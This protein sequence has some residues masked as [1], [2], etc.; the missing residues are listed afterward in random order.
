MDD[1][2][3]PS[4]QVLDMDKDSTSNEIPDLPEP[5]RRAAPQPSKNTRLPQK[6]AKAI[7]NKKA[8]G[9]DIDK[10]DATKNKETEADEINVKDSNESK[11]NNLKGD[12]KKRTRACNYLE[13]KNLQICTSWLETTK[14]GRKGTNQTGD[15]FWATISK[16]YQK[17]IPK[18]ERTSKNLKN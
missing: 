13:H 6:T 5:R 4:L 12:P 11:D 1:T 16:H 3:D 18:P 2:L 9:F 7:K 15:A 14:D 8:K 17:Q 10:D